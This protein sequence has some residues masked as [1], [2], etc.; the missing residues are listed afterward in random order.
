M[1][2]ANKVL[3]Y[4][5]PLNV[6]LGI[7]LIV[8]ISLAVGAMWAIWQLQLLFKA[9]ELRR[10]ARAAQENEALLGAD[11]IPSVVLSVG[12]G[13]RDFAF[14]TPLHPCPKGGGVEVMENMFRDQECLHPCGGHPTCL[15][16]G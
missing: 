10:V 6:F 5:G 7:Y 13:D 1:N 11:A 12:L 4:L 9:R 15:L 14:V 16:A 2:T 8:V 3:D